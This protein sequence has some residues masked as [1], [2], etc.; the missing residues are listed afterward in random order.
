M[1]KSLDHL[2]RTTLIIG[3]GRGLRQQQQP[4]GEARATGRGRTA[5][6][7]GGGGGLMSVPPIRMLGMWH[8]GFAI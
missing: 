4:E 3:G 1:I 7:G 2:P 8:R 5:A 6:A